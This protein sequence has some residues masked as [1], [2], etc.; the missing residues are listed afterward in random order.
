MTSKVAIIILNWNGWEDTIECLESVYQIKYP[1]YDIIVVDNGSKDK[2]IEKIKEYAA[3]NILIESNFFKYNSNNKPIH[4]IEHSPEELKFSDRIRKDLDSLPL[5]K[6]LII[7]KNNENYGFAEGNNIAIKYSLHF[8]DPDYVLLLNNDV[9]VDSGFLD[10]LILNAESDQ[11]IGVLGPTIYDYK[12]PNQ[13]QSAGSRV[14]W[15][16][17][18]AINLT[19]EHGNIPKIPQ[20]VDS[21]IG[22]AL[23]AKSKLFD[24]IGY[25]NRNY[26][27][28]F[29]ETE[30]C[31][32]ARNANYKIMYIPKGKVW[33]K[34]GAT[35]NKI[36]GFALYHYTRNR[37]WFMKQHAS[38]KQYAIFISY[39]LGFKFFS[40]VGWALLNRNKPLLISFLKGVRD[41]LLVNG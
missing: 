24:E 39:F 35:S 33:H 11:S 38:H 4:L 34:G 23:L 15:N 32:R 5:E 22:C 12:P 20:E 28:Y 30:W 17:G 41:G 14:L 18:E 1:N 40:F 31:V 13:I 3:G 7:I 19:Y 25:L 9:V 2:S 37:F 21:V 26:F 27:A 16:K 6:K 29:E 10:E 8:L 36:T